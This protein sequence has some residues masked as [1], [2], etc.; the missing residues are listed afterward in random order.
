MSFD[1]RFHVYL[2]AFTTTVH[3]EVSRKCFIVENLIKFGVLSSMLLFT[4]RV[5]ECEFEQN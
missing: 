3:Y 2:F 4:D 1:C 5:S